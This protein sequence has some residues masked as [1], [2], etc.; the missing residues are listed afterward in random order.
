MKVIAP[1]AY[2]DGKDKIW[3]V[4]AGTVVDGASIPRAFWTV[5]GAPYTGQYREAAVVHDRYCENKERPWSEVHQAFYD[6]MRAKGVG[7]IQAQ[8]M[9]AAVYSFGPRWV[10]GED[11]NGKAVLIQ[12][13]PQ[14]DEQKKAQIEAYA[15]EGQRSIDEIK[16]FADGVTK[17]SEGEVKESPADC[18]VV[19]PPAEAAESA[20]LLCGLDKKSQQLNSSRNLS[21][22]IADLRKLAGSNANLLIPAIEGYRADPTE[23]NWIHAKDQAARIRAL[24]KLAT[25]S[26]IDYDASLTGSLGEETKQLFTVLQTR[27]VMLDKLTLNDQPQN[28]PG[29]LDDWIK[30]Y[31][32]LMAR[33]IV[34]LEHLQ[35]KVKAGS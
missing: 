10:V 3:R 16:K 8:V 21:I 12:G 22:L 31:Q 17:A 7:Y 1:F 5:I 35:M 11:R 2:I 24:I 30:R 29:Y 20:Y 13:Q 9:Y 15:G 33:L 26:A 25:L 6:G 28:D 27:G 4:P 34:E 19:V 32:A 18:G 23:A 14:F